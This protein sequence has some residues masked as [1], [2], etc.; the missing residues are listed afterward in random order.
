MVSEQ[1][2]SG[3]ASWCLHEK[4]RPDWKLWN[5]DLKGETH[6]DGDQTDSNDTSVHHDHNRPREEGTDAYGWLNKMDR[7]FELK[8]MNEREKLQAVMVAMEG[9]ALA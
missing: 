9:K 3:T 5:V 8:R 6:G 2:P 1:L 4:W 7:Y